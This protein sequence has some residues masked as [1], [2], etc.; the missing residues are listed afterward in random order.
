MSDLTDLMEHALKTATRIITNGLEVEPM[1][2]LADG[3]DA[4]GLVPTPWESDTE[5]QHYL[6]AVR[7]ILEDRQIAYYA[8]VSE[9]WL[10]SYTNLDDK[11]RPS[12]RD[13][14]Q[15]VLIVTGCTRDY[16][17][18]LLWTVPIITRDGRRELGEVDRKIGM[19]GGDMAH[20][21]KQGTLQ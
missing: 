2:L 13:D 11:P 14:R 7:Q 17:E 21:F 6:A 20:M 16:S 15:E 3:D 18:Q 12:E 19:T 9:A 10:A 1:W 4:V 8:Q 5:K